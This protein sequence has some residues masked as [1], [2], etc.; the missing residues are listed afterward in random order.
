[1]RLL[2]EILI[3]LLKSETIEV[4]FPNFNKSTRE[5]VEMKSYVI[6]RKIKELLEEDSD[7]ESC[8]MKIEQIMDAF[9]TNGI[10]IENR[11]DF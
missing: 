1:M 8:F 9:E 4:T 2:K 3:D 7:D 11:H 5:A 6:L 10:T